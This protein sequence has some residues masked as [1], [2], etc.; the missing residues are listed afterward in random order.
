MSLT[1]GKTK[2]PNTDTSICIT[3]IENS[4]EQ[5]KC[6]GNTLVL[7]GK[8]EDLQKTLKWRNRRDGDIILR[9]KMH[10]QLRRLWAQ[11]GVPTEVRQTLPLLCC[12][13]EIVWAPFVGTSDDFLAK[14]GGEKIASAWKIEIDILNNLF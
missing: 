11:A 7:F 2:I 10:R 4:P 12:G 6:E 9:G 8:W 3:P 1:L 13:E 14:T 5:D